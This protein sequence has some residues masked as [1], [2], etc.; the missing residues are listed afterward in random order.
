MRLTERDKHILEAIHAFDG[1]LGFTQIQRLF[2]TGKAQTELRLML[3]YQHQF[4]NRPNRKQRQRLPEMIYWLDRRGAEIVAAKQSQ[5]L[6]EFKWRKKPRW[7]QAEHDLAVNDFR[8]DVQE[9][10]RKSKDVQ[11][12]KWIPESEFWADSDKVSY[13]FSGRNM[14]R[15]IRPDGFFVLTTLKSRIRYL[16]EIDRSTEDNPRFLREKITPGLAYI[17][18]KA[19]RD[20]FGHPTG[21]WLVVTTGDRRLSNMLSQARRAKANGLFFFTTSFIT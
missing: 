19:F 3:L 2:F 6:V 20:R 21:R 11:L 9:A 14:K 15:K 12:E 13:Y 18:S 4:V 1:M 16:L 10:T 5:T 17:G 7:F 8:M